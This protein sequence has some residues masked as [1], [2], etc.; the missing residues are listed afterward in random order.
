M[1]F[2][3]SLIKRFSSVF[4]CVLLLG[5][6]SCGRKAPPVPPGTLRP[7]PIK[8][9]AFRVTEKGIELKWLVPLRNMDGSPLAW[10]KG[11]RLYRA[12]VPVDSACDTC[13]PSFENPVWIPFGAKPKVAQTITYEDRTVR[14]GMIYTYKVI[15][16]KGWLNLSD[17][18][19]LITAAWHMPPDVPSQV[20]FK[21]TL[22]GIKISWTGPQTWADGT[23]LDEKVVY[24]VYRSRHGSGTW[25]IISDLLDRTECLDLTAKRG[26]D[27]LYKVAAVIIYHN[28]QIEG[29]RSEPIHVFFKDVVPPSRPTGLVAEISDSGVELS[30]QEN[31]EHDLAGYLIYR[32]SQAGIIDRLNQVP[33]R[34]SRF[35][36]RT[37]LRPGTYV[38]WVTAVDRADP[39]NES[40]ASRP[41]AVTITH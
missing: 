30:W 17:S 2:D 35:L 34:I 14:P 39:P 3:N 29:N 33:V 12:R 36:D 1:V 25:K 38:Y 13:P 5:L 26:R 28:T 32:K 27:Y 6:V 7:Q 10:I 15:T 11:F 24:R 8:N 21:L 31:F 23:P 16:D 18:S 41:V 19:N 40:P 9:F 22:K 4:L 37:R 20:S